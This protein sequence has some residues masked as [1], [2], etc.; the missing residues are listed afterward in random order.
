[1]KNKIVLNRH[2]ELPLNDDSANLFLEIMTAIAVFLFAVTLAGYLT[3]NS[4]VSDWNRG[5]SGSFTVQIMPS[6]QMIE[7]DEAGLRVNKVIKY[8]ENLEVVDKVILMNDKQMQRLMRPWLGSEIDMAALPLPQLLD[9]RLRPGQDL[10]YENA[11]AEL[12]ELAP[13][14]S[15]DN[16][17]VWLDRLIK[18]ASSLQMLALSVLAMVLAVCAFS[19]FY[20][21]RTSLGIHAQIIEILHVM[22]AKDDYIARQYAQRSFWIGLFSGF[23]GAL[24]AI[25]ALYVIKNMAA[26]LDSGLI[27]K[28]VLGVEDW[29]AIISLPLWAAVLSM[30][31]AYY[32]VRRTLGK[33]V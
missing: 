24:L 18:F 6:E 15:I 21:T 11:A 9:V 27:G 16:H 12:A 5:I 4:I 30:L 13:Y 17:R 8:F 7:Q 28:A 23:A 3:V 32:T 33:I 1:M 29:L 19:I 22:G 25:A 14:T 20:A 31:T 26:E 2:S 10:D